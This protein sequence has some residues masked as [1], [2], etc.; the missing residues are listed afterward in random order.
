MK[1]RSQEKLWCSKKAQPH[2]QFNRIANICHFPNRRAYG[3]YVSLGKNDFRFRNHQHFA[4]LHHFR[5]NGLFRNSPQAIN[6]FSVQHRLWN[7][8]GQRHSIYGKIPPRP[9]S[10]QR[11]NQKISFQRL[12][13]N[14]NQYLLHLNCPDFWLRRIYTFQ[15]WRHRSAGR[16]NFLHLTIC[17]VRQPFGFAR[18]GPHI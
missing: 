4:A 10:K 15:L 2:K 6:D 8:R 5:I 11:K 3:V 18:F 13:R 17:N 16:L 9:H 7:F 12:A 14:R 1:L